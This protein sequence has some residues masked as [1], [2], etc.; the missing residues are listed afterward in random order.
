M[1]TDTALGLTVRA[2]STVIF[3]NPQTIF[4]M[5]N[6]SMSFMPVVD[7]KIAHLLL[8]V[9][10]VNNNDR[11]QFTMRSPTAEMEALVLEQ[12]NKNQLAARRE[13]YNIN[14]KVGTP[15]AKATAA[16]M[17]NQLHVEFLAL[18]GVWK[19][20][21]IHIGSR[22]KKTAKKNRWKPDAEH[23]AWLVIDVK[24]IAIHETE[25]PV[26]PKEKTLITRTYISDLTKLQPGHLY[27]PN[28]QN[29]ATYDSFYC[30][31]RTEAIIFQATEGSSAH[32]VKP[33]GRKWLQEKGI[34]SAVYILVSGPKEPGAQLPSLD[35]P[36]KEASFYS[37]CWYMMLDYPPIEDLQLL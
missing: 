19:L 37:K 29:F 35:M 6:G 30:K 14:I 32:S 10:P 26:T 8:T 24:G 17:L 1:K 21:G 18:G 7:Q 13:L 5:V 36:V 31:T 12:L 28:Q 9:L 22:A 34:Q 33:G 15:G 27:R 20:H 16:S 3:L 25:P 11:R 2:R 4:S 23:S